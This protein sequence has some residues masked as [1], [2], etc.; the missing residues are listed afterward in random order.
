M[1]RGKFFARL[2]IFD[3]DQYELEVWDHELE[4][5]EGGQESVSKWARRHLEC[6]CDFREL[7]GLPKEGDFQV[8]FSG[9][10]MGWWGGGYS[11]D[12]WEE[13]LE[14]EKCLFKE[15]PAEYAKYFY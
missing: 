3:I 1:V 10:I 13:D 12:E 11:P 15:M 2:Y 7:L 9:E 8:I 14:I 5:M 4:P 6:G